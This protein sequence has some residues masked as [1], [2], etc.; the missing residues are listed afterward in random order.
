M[1]QGQSFPWSRASINAPHGTI[2]AGIEATESIVPAADSNQFWTASVRLLVV[3]SL[4]PDKARDC[5]GQLG[6][7]GEPWAPLTA[8][9]AKFS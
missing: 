2:K 9:P 4:K 3:S 8:P 5:R 1:A 6:L 7:L